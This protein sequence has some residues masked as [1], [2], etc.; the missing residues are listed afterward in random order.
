MLAATKRPDPRL[1]ARRWASINRDARITLHDSEIHYLTAMAL[2]A[3]D[4]L[5]AY[6]L[7]AKLRMAARVSNDG[8]LDVVRMN[9]L[10]EFEFGGSEKR[11]ARL[12]HPSATQQSSNAVPVTSI[13]GAGLIGLGAGQAVSWPDASGSLRPLKIL[14]VADAS[15][16]PALTTKRKEQQ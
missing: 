11:V 2:A 8:P 1:I 6:L 14:R 10:V 4:D 12:V 16:A 9:S 5:A 3:D 13:A 7:L 15:V